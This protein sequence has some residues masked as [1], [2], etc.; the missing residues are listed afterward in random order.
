M[1]EI[2]RIQGQTTVTGNG[3][4]MT[5]P[6]LNYDGTASLGYIDTGFG[7]PLRGQNIQITA[8][9]VAGN[10]NALFYTQTSNDLISW[11][12][13]VFDDGPEINTTTQRVIHDATRN[14]YIRLAWLFDV[15]D[16]GE[17][18]GN[19]SSLSGQ[20]FNSSSSGGTSATS[21]SFYAGLV[22]SETG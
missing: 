4:S 18:S 14:R 8:N 11:K 13:H 9:A 17:S 7:T 10:P 19:S 1:Q 12:D 22:I 2:T 6:G 20:S 15:F 21:L 3:N 5:A 16:P